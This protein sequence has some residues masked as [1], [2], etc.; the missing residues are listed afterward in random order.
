MKLRNLRYFCAVFDEQSTVGAARL[1]HVTQ[2]AIS[3]ALAQLEDKLGVRLFVREQRGLT[4]TPAAQRLYRLACKLLADAEAIEASFRDAT[5][6]RQLRLRIQPTLN[7]GHSRR[8]L[9][10]LRREMAH[11]EISVVEAGQAADLSLTSASCADAGATFIPLWAE[12]YALIVPEDHPLAV[13]ERIELAD[14]HGVAFIERSHCEL[15][16]AWHA[17]TA[18][19]GPQ[20]SIRARVSSEEWALG[21]VAAGVGVT[22]APL[23]AL[24]TLAGVVVR[25]D[26]PA[27]QGLSRTVGLAYQAPVGAVL[28]E[29]LAV[30]QRWVEVGWSP[31]SHAL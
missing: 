21:L 23:H 6:E 29:V 24:T 16:A 13:R 12:T 11:L 30:C 22:V 10:Q 2:P 20:P 17:F 8:L 5:L 4:P 15:S 31:A 7:I 19:P 9:R 1:C 18:T 27:L 14:L 3:A 28:A 26:V 25:S